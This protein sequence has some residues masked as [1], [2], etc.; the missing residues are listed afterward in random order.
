MTNTKKDWKEY[1]KEKKLFIRDFFNLW[2][3]LIGMVLFS[4][5]YA[6][7]IPILK[8]VDLTH[9]STSFCT[10]QGFDWGKY[11]ER[12]IDGFECFNYNQTAVLGEHYTWKEINLVLEEK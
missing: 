12:R 11:Y 6:Y 2:T 4:V 3:L 8:T 9:E 1:E 5:F 10:S 7:G